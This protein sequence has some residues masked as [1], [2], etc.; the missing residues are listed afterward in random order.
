MVA[1]DS[2]PGELISVAIVAED[3]NL[4]IFVAGSYIWP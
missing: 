1:A 2:C 3:S 4:F